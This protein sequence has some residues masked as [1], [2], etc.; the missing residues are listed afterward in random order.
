MSAKPAPEA[1]ISKISRN[2]IIT[3]HSGRTSPSDNMGDEIV[4]VET[5]VM[6]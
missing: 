4:A 5:L 6:L 1:M 3:F 2:L